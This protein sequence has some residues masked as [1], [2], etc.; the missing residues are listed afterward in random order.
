MYSPVGGKLEQAIGESPYQCAR[1]E[2][3]EE[4][5][6][7]LEYQDLRLCGIVAEKAY[8]GA[9]H[10]LMFCFEVTRSVSL[11]QLEIPE[12]R[13]EWVPISE[14]QDRPIPESDR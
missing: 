3:R 9:T 13:L 5:G 1:R 14:V 10:W 8:E 12:G 4:I 6:L 2:V 7:T 11:T